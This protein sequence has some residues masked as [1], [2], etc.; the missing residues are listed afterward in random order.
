MLT[1]EKLFVQDVDQIESIVVDV[2]R[3]M[4]YE[5][6]IWDEAHSNATPNFTGT[7]LNIVDLYQGSTP[8]T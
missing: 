2:R 6:S 4:S 7:E 5:K 3:Y 8:N 1:T